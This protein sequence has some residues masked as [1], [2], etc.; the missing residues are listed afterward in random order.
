MGSTGGFPDLFVVEPLNQ[1]THT[2]ILLHGRGSM[3]AEFAEELFE[4]RSSAGMSLAGHFP[5]FK[6]VFPT[7]EDRYSTTFQE[8]LTE[9]FDIR[10]LSDPELDFS[11]QIE[12]IKSSTTYL[13]KILR[14]E[15]EIVPS[16]RIVLG[17]I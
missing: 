7:S 10:S 4:A 17:G 1:H 13:S 8:N 5:S 16:S 3:G 6:W 12:G 11:L 9:W 14:K 2:I 15:S